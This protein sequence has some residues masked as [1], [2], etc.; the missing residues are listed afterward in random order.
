MPDTPLGRLTMLELPDDEFV[1]IELVSDPSAGAV[2]G[3]SPIGDPEGPR[4]A[5]LTDPDGNRIELV[6]W[7]PG[8]PEG[9]TATDLAT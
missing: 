6:Q 9:M 7:P 2:D 5:W 8:H 1:T 3:L 4:T